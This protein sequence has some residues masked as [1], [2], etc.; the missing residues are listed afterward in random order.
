MKVY[1][2]ALT[3]VKASKIFFPCVMIS[4]SITNSLT[5]FE[6][7]TELSDDHQWHNTWVVKTFDEVNSCNFLIVLLVACA[8]RISAECY[9]LKKKR[10]VGSV[11][12]S[13]CT[14]IR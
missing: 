4:K 12:N 8:G 3:N 1:P 6:D 2:D 10:L 11:I 14:I 9:Q 7:D 13:E 5:H